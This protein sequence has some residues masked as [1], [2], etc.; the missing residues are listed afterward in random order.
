VE[1]EP[2][3][4]GGNTDMRRAF[5]I[6]AAIIACVFCVSGSAQP[7]TQQQPSVQPQA[8]AGQA[9]AAMGVT[10]T[11]PGVLTNAQGVVIQDTV[12]IGT[13]SFA[14]GRTGTIRI[15]TKGLDRQRHDVN[16]GSNQTTTIYNGGI[17]Y[18]IQGTNRSRLPLWFTQYHRSEHIPVL[19]RLADNQL[20]NSIMAYSGLETL[21][22]ASVQHIQLTSTPTD[23]TPASIEALIS[24]FHAF[25]DPQTGLVVKIRTLDFSPQ[26]IEN[27][28]AVE[29][30]FSDYRIVNGI[31]VP[32][33]MSRFFGP[34]KY[35]DITFT[36]VSIN[37]GISDSEFQ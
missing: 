1:C 18:L 30:F 5:V 4:Y 34:R 6:G 35:Y 23:G 14:D 8:I 15:E 12:A 32:F 29:T 10:E 11:V 20:P 33:S 3:D 36:S 16:I 28:K 2:D 9:L 22:G 19:S 17:G 26:I 37:T 27:R 24:E 13:I 25:V 7:Q 31:L 21:N